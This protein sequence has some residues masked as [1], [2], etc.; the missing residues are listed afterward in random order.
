MLGFSINLRVMV[1]LIKIVVLRL[2]GGLF[3]YWSVMIFRRI[4]CAM[5]FSRGINLEVFSR[6]ERLR[7][8]NVR[9]IVHAL[10][11]QQPV[12]V[13]P[14]LT[15]GYDDMGTPVPYIPTSSLPDFL[16]VDL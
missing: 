10:I 8:A 16:I 1:V 12:K 11:E 5:E 7:I 15:Q 3:F 9:S 4:L 13:E 6:R 2:C 14:A